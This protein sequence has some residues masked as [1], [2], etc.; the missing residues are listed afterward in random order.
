M[1]LTLS[2]S[3]T[4]LKV[5]DE[6]NA[7]GVT[8]Q[9]AVCQTYWKCTGTDE[10]GNTGEFQGATPFSAATVSEGDFTAF[11]D[12]VEADVVGWVQAVV[13]GDAGYKAHIEE[14]I[15][16]QI[17]ADVARDASMP[18]AEDVTPPLPDDAADPAPV[19]PAD[20]EA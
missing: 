18:W 13:D 6:V 7:D 11:E 3:I 15:Q 10:D 4:N 14:Q 1:A 5:K 16:R 2:Y 8:L 17:D 9:N 12:L 20:P 19:N